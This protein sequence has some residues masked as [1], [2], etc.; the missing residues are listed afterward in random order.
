MIL[1]S[2]LGSSAILE[3]IED[4]ELTESAKEE[5]N[6][7]LKRSFRPEF[8]NRLDEIVFFKPLGEGEV[9]KIVKLFE[10]EL[11]ERLAEKQIVLKVDDSA[12]E[13]IIRRG[14]DAVYGA[15][16]LKRFMQRTVQTM[17]AKALL[18]GEFTAGD[19][20]LVTVENGEFAIRKE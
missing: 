8:L 15:R 16:P 4:G 18:G 2:N 17:I 13:L 1:T 5:V 19:T 3:G 14:Y 9:A 11:S 10:R 12:T 7:M 20:L 6:A